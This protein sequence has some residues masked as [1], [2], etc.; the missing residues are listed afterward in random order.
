[1]SIISRFHVILLIITFSTLLFRGLPIR[2]EESNHNTYLYVAFSRTGEARVTSVDPLNKTS[3]IKRGTVFPTNIDN[4]YTYP[5]WVAPSH[6]WFLINDQSTNASNLRLI[7]V[8]LSSEKIIGYNVIGINLSI[9]LRPDQTVAWSPNSQYIAFIARSGQDS[10][11]NNTLHWGAYLYSVQTSTLTRLPIR[12]NMP[13]RFAWSADSKYLAIEGGTDQIVHQDAND[14]VLLEV[15]N[16]QIGKVEKIDDLSNLVGAYDLGMCNMNW[17]PDDQYI[18]FVS[19]CDSTRVGNIAREVYSFNI[20]TGQTKQV[21]NLATHMLS[22][23]PIYVDSQF[24]LNWLSPSHLMIGQWVSVQGNQGKPS[25]QIT[26]TLLYDPVT[27]NTSI[28]SSGKVQALSINPVNGRLA[29]SL[30]SAI[31]AETFLPIAAQVKTGNFNAATNI[32]SIESDISLPDGNNFA[33]SSDGKILAYQQ[34][35]TNNFIF[36]TDGSSPT[37]SYTFSDSSVA[38]DSASKT[39]YILPIGWVGSAA[40]GTVTPTLVAQPTN[41][42][43]PTG[44]SVPGGN[45]IGGG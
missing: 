8:D 26:Q 1:M 29:V 7:N 2:A 34:T 9:E 22:M 17:S 45:Q 32:A 5:S 14:A 6:Q 10:S 24:S 31:S 23:K 13:I 38:A 42:P 16:A 3:E 39:A 15:W 33:W 28:Y 18:A 37:V 35:G 41:G 12:Q 40:P 27:T 4:L 11:N 21:T 25:P 20:K 19:I 43:T 44:A 36:V 30:A